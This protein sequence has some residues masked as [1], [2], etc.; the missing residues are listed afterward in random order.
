MIYYYLGRERLLIDCYLGRSRLL[1]DCYPGTTQQLIDCYLGRIPAIDRLLVCYIWVEPRLLI[2]CYLGRLEPRLL[3]DCYLGRAPATSP[4]SPAMKPSAPTANIR[5][6]TALK[7]TDTKPKEG[8]HVLLI[9]KQ[10][11][12]CLNSSMYF[13]TLLVYFA[14]AF[15]FSFVTKIYS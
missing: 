8:N 7:F 5:L 6:G 3:I 9:V 15:Y 1:I 12:Y 2:D 4:S 14:Y 10:F 13:I 11:K